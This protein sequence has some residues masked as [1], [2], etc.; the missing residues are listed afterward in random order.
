MVLAMN[1]GV[2]IDAKIVLISDP[3]HVELIL[4][5]IEENHVTFYPGVPTMYHVINKN[6]NAKRGKR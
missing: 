5:E 4:K 3:T 2:A 6:E 1:M